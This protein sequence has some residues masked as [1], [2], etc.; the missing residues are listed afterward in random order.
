MYGGGRDRP[1]MRSHISH[2]V[3]I[4]TKDGKEELFPVE[5]YETIYEL[6]IPFGFFDTSF[7]LTP[8]DENVKNYMGKLRGKIKLA[9][10]K[11]KRMRYKKQLELLESA[12]KIV[13]S[14]TVWNSLSYYT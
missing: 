1:R 6:D 7:V 14:R 10:S 11:E 12:A 4:T 8:V 2:G 13:V 5:P 9:E 3:T